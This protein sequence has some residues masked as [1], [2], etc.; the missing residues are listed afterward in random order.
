MV[1]GNAVTQLNNAGFR[2]RVHPPEIYALERGL[3]GARDTEAV[4]LRFETPKGAV[5]LNIA[6]R[7]RQ[8]RSGAPLATDVLCP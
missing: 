5:F 3:Q 4:V 1:I 7:Y 2:F 6:V 8:R